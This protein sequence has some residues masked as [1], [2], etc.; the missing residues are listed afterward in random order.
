M[1]NKKIASM[2]E[3]DAPLKDVVFVICDV[4]HQEC[5]KV[6][7][8]P[9][10]QYLGW[11]ESDEWDEWDVR[12]A[13]TEWQ[14][15]QTG[16]EEVPID[17]YHYET[18]NVVIDVM[19]GAIT[20]HTIGMVWD[21][22]VKFRFPGYEMAWMPVPDALHFDQIPSTEEMETSVLKHIQAWMERLNNDIGN[23]KLTEVRADRWG[24]GNV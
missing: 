4:L 6:L 13:I 12:D 18:E 22:W 17:K 8:A 14:H 24:D 11:E 5:E 15:V 2:V 19:W 21:V 23:M 3:P 9:V 7:L 1:L 20:P 16:K 10:L